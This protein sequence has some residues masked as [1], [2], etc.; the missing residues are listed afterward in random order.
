MVTY[1]FAGWQRQSSMRLTAQCAERQKPKAGSEN[2]EED[3]DPDMAAAMG[4]GGFGT[5]KK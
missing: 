4:F 5:S 1:F 3:L 2:E